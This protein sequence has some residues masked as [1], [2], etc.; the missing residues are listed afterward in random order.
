MRERENEQRLGL[1]D[2]RARSTSPPSAAVV[3]QAPPVAP[4]VH[5]EV[6]EEKSKKQ[7]N[8]LSKPRPGSSGSKK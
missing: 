8:R 6:V 2:P 5:E 1:M 7:R 4:E 3:A